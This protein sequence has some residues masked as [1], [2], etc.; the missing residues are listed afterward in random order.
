M[1][2]DNQITAAKLFNY[3]AGDFILNDNIFTGDSTTTVAKHNEIKVGR[4]GIIRV[5]Y[6][7][8]GTDAYFTLRNNGTIVDTSRIP[9]N[10][11]TLHTKDLTVSAGDLI[12]IYINTGGVTYSETSTLA[13]FCNGP[14]ETGINKT[15]TD[16]A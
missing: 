15:Y 14:I 7:V 13:I 16:Y 9:G 8:T 6:K 4:D 5:K 1:V 10:M 12:Q 3:T 11:N 2:A